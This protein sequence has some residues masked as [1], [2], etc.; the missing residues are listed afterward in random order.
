MVVWGVRR[1]W[2][3]SSLWSDGVPRGGNTNCG[4]RREWRAASPLSSA[5]LYNL[6][7]YGIEMRFGHAA[8]S[9][10]EWLVIC[11]VFPKSDLVELLN[12]WMSSGR[13]CQGLVN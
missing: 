3:V 1:V 6:F 7:T 2:A 12:F 10:C 4:A 11:P 8:E 5:W 9:M 13:P